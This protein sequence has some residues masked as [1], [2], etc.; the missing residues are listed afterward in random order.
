[1][2]RDRT[3]TERA[4]E[5][6][7][8]TDDPQEILDLRATPQESERLEELLQKNRNGSLSLREEKELDLILWG[9]HFVQL[10]KIKAFQK[11]Q[12]A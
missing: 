8:I 5:R 9:E 7:L 6:V 11:L 2:V 3:F 4:L 10:A 1:M 12:R